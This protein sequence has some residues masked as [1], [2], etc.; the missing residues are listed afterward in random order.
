MKTPV[1]SNLIHLGN[2]PIKSFKRTMTTVAAPITESPE[3]EDLQTPA[4]VFKKSKK[5]ML[6]SSVDDPSHDLFQKSKTKFGLRGE[7]RTRNKA[8]LSVA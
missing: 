6:V 4:R 7:K 1:E 8:A 3:Y 5:N 2:Y